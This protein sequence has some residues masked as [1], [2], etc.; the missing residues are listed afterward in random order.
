[1]IRAKAGMKRQNFLS[2]TLPQI[3]KSSILKRDADVNTQIQKLPII[4]V[5][6]SFLNLKEIV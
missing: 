3:P 2:Q 5:V 4:I 1:M 6:L